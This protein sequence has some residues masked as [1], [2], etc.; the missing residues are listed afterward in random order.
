MKKIFLIALLS[1]FLYA[2]EREWAFSSEECLIDSTRE[3]GS[4]KSLANVFTL[5]FDIKVQDYKKSEGMGMVCSW[6][7]G[8]DN[9]WRLTI[10]P[11]SGAYHAVFSLGNTEKKRRSVRFVGALS[12]NVVSHLTVTFD[13]TNVKLYR[14]GALNAAAQTCGIGRAKPAS[15]AF[16]GARHGIAFYPFSVSKVKISPRVKSDEEILARY[17]EV[18]KAEDRSKIYKRYKADK[19]MKDGKYLEA[20]SFYAP[21]YEEAC[22]EETPR[23]VEVAF[24]YADALA[25]AGKVDEAKEVWK[26]IAMSND[27]PPY[28]TREA[29]S[30][31]GISDPRPSAPYPSTDQWQ[32]KGK[33]DCVFFVANNGDDSA[34]GTKEKPLATISGAL[35]RIRSYRGEKG[36]PKNGAAILIRGGRYKMDSTVVLGENDG[37]E[38]NA[39]LIISSWKGEDVILDGAKEISSWRKANEEEIKSLR[40]DAKK[41]VIVADLTEAEYGIIEPLKS[42]GF[43][44]K[45]GGLVDLIADG[46][47]M[48]LARYPNSGFAFV[49]EA[50][51][52]GSFRAS[53]E[54]LSGWENE[55]DVFVTGYWNNFWSDRTLKVESIDSNGMVTLL[56][57]ERGKKTIVKKGAAVFL[58]NALRALDTQGEWFFDRKARKVFVW[59]KKDVKRWSLGL[60]KTPAI[61]LD[62]TKNVIINGLVVEGFSSTAIMMNDVSD[63]FVKNSTVRNCSRVGIKSNGKRVRIE[64]CS[65]Y[66]LGRTAVDIHGGSRKTLERGDNI[67]IDCEAWDLGRYWRTY[68]PAVH[69]TG[70]GIDIVGNKFHDLLSSAIRA[71]ANDVRVISNRVWRCVLE[72]DDQGAFDIY[73]NPTFAG[74]EIAYNHWSDIGDG[75]IAKTGQAAVRLDDIVSGVVIHN[76]HFVRSSRGIFGAV[77]M[78]GGRRNFVDSNVFEDCRL[79]VSMQSRSDKR[80]AELL[81]KFQSTFSSP[82]YRERYPGFDKLP[83]ASPAN[84]IWRNAIKN[85]KRTCRPLSLYENL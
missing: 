85:V 53:F 13:G 40:G 19:A 65:F 55:C 2:E 6:G 34:E 25:L 71:D 81:K 14:D 60:Q 58:T 20:V 37:G 21:L 8:Y 5:D 32:A 57:S 72:S 39:P 9:G 12:T 27:L 45:G 69:T 64:G 4:V 56:R 41:N 10:R 54:D 74:V 61:K 80:W 51:T 3:L 68:S 70:C 78:N 79:D 30:K 50:S 7:N 62:R 83:T 82:V 52:N 43:G 29:A 15:F 46:D 48:T 33:I 23:R 35:E 26:K 18:V 66:S 59:P 36:W 73:A 1:S 28:F 75:D 22:L 16:G 84:Y 44:L 24:A 38:E 63:I 67:V 76:N 42:Y 11:S 31:A 49:E 17:E 77:Q 47:V